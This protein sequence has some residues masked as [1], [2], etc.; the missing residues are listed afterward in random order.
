MRIYVSGSLAY[1]RIMTF[2]G[3]FADHILPDKIHILNVCF[4]VN[5]LTEKFGG[6]AGNIAYTMSLLG[7]KPLILATSGKDFGAYKD[8]LGSL[9]LSLDGIKHVSDEFTAGAYITTDLSDNQITG[10]NP[11]AMKHPCGYAF[12]GLEPARDLAIVSPGNLDDMRQF[13]RFYKERGVR[14]LFDPG[15]NITAFPGEVLAEMITGANYF[16][17]NDYELEMVM[18]ATGLSKAELLERTPVIITTLGEN[19]SLISERG[20]ETKI[21]AAKVASPKDPTGA[22]DAFRAGLLKGLA[23]GKSLADA[24]RVGSVAAAYAVEGHGTQEHKFTMSEFN[25]RYVKNFGG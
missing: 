20:R 9:G 10:F 13:P 8:W 1:D 3:K 24:A 6:T 22:G 12:P 5:G 4:L 7:E 2:P 23:D 18:N 11:G 16:I 19:G 14:F 21:G 15:Q 25:E 17:S